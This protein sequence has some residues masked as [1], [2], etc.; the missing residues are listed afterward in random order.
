MDSIAII[1]ATA[2]VFYAVNILPGAIHEKKYIY[3]LGATILLFSTF[4]YFSFPTDDV[5]KSLIDSISFTVFDFC[6]GVAVWF[7]FHRVGRDL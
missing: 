4:L 6:I 2:G 7:F 3:A 1:N 5:Q